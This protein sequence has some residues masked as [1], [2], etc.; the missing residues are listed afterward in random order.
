[1][2]MNQDGTIKI[3]LR[4]I[5]KMYTYFIHEN[6]NVENHNSLRKSMQ[7]H[8]V[9]KMV[10]SK[11]KWYITCTIEGWIGDNQCKMI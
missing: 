9:K 2:C 5:Q 7:K 3:V 6:I 8:D 10:M 1:M 11:A 4:K